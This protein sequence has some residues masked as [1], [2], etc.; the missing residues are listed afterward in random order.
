MSENYLKH[1]EK[2]RKEWDRVTTQIRD[3]PIIW[4]KKYSKESANAKKIKLNKRMEN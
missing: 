2:Y 3:R 4:V 1:S